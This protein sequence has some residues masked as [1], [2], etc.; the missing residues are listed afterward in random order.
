MTATCECGL[1]S[2]SLFHSIS[3]FLALS[4]SRAS[5]CEMGAI[6]CS[7][8][9]RISQCQ[10]TKSAT[11]LSRSHKLINLWCGFQR[12]IN[13]SG[14]DRSQSRTRSRSQGSELGAQGQLPPIKIAVKTHYNK[15]ASERASERGT[16]R[17][18]SQQKKRTAN[19]QHVAGNI[20]L[21]LYIYICVCM[22]R[23]YVWLMQTSQSC[24]TSC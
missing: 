18:I 8:A 17:I 7:S 19:G 11:P 10:S 13:A 22:N 21:Q 24:T 15:G 3:L 1:V 16:A 6:L 12:V 9:R 20:Q 4:V 2:R 23:L 14:S 5:S